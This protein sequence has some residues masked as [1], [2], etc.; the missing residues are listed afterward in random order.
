MAPDVWTDIAA[1]NPMANERLGYATQK[2]VALLER[3]IK[4]GS[5]EGDVVF[6]PFCGSATTIEA[7]HKLDRGWIGI[8]MAIHAIKRVARVRLQDR[9]G[10]IEGTDF[11][12]TGV[13]RTMETARDLWKRDRHY[14]QKWAIEEIDGFVIRPAKQTMTELTAGCISIT[15]IILI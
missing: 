12:I 2:P 14:F 1:I 11:E 4:A 6:D 9:L 5:N 15:R 13:P 3:I 8:D 10:L 7:A